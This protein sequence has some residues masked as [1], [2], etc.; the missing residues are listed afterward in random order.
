MNA[1]LHHFARLA[2]TGNELRPGIVH[3]IDKDTSGAIAVTKS[4]EA[5]RHLSE[6]FARH[7]IARTYHALVIAPRLEDSGTIDTF[8]GRHPKDRLKFSSLVSDGR[9]AVTHYR[10]LERFDRHAVLVECKLETGRTHQIRVHLTDINAPLLGDVLYAPRNIGPN[11]LI[12]RQ[13]LH[14]RTLGFVHVDGSEV[15]VEAPYPADFA[16]ALEALRAGRPF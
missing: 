10:V 11:K 8:H 2:P 7:D 15:L 12:D 4:P 3:R 6:L 9:R 14:A 13:A 1:V 16:T 5:H